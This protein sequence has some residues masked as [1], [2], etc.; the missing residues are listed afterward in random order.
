MLLSTAMVFIFPVK[1]KT[2][3]FLGQALGTLQAGRTPRQGKRGGG[4]VSAAVHTSHCP[5][6]VLT[7][8]RSLFQGVALNGGVIPQKS[9]R[10]HSPFHQLSTP[11]A[12]AP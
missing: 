2:A 9:W 4:A 6:S 1:R 7:N 3:R 12:A 5:L 11:T 8:S 10:M